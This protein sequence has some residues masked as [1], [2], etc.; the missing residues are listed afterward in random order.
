MP[1]VLLTP[2]SVIPAGRLDD[3]GDEPLLLELLKVFCTR[4]LLLM[5]VGVLPPILVV[6]S[7]V[8]LAVLRVIGVLP[9]LTVLMVVGMRMFVA[10]VPPVVLPLVVEV[11]RI[12]IRLVN[13][14]L[15]AFVMV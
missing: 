12:R 4:L 8:K 14:P 9:P 1:V 15:L 13:W 7:L 3:D 5:I 2:L 6:L 11:S 10:G